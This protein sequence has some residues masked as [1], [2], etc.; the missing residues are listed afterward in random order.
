MSLS[1]PGFAR[2]GQPTPE[3]AQALYNNAGWTNKK[4]RGLNPGHNVNDFLAAAGTTG[5]GVTVPVN[6]QDVYRSTN[7][8][9]RVIGDPIPNVVPA[10]R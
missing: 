5:G 1:G 6:Y 10:Q 4:G 3:E 2:P 7:V 9:S 8:N